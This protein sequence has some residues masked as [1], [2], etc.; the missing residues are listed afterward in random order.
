MD[1]QRLSDERRTEEEDWNTKEHERK[2]EEEERKTGEVEDSNTEKED[3][4]NTE[5]EDN[6]FIAASPELVGLPDELLLLIFK[7]LSLISRPAG[8]SSYYRDLA[9]LS[10]VG[11]RRLHALA[12]SPDQ[13]TDFSITPDCNPYD[14]CWA[15]QQP[16]NY[17][18]KELSICLTDWTTN[19]ILPMT[20]RAIHPDSQVGSVGA[21]WE[22]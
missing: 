12:T 7:K 18:L 21:D 16:R 13:W 1:K 14:L 22:L 2:A 6:N 11:N 3:N 17:Q 20:L 10:M 9:N 15:L 4:M 5:K 8:S 19:Q